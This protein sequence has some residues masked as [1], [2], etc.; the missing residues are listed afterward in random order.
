MRMRLLMFGLLA[1]FVL[2]GSAWAAPVTV[3]FS[4]L[5]STVDITVQ[6]NPAPLTLNGV[7]IQFD[8]Y[9]ISTDYASADSMGIYGHSENGPVVLNFNNGFPDTVGLPVRKLSLDFS[10]ESVTGPV[11]DDSGGFGLLAYVST[12]DGSVGDSVTLSGTYA[13]YDPNVPDL[14][15]VTGHLEYEGG[16][17]FDQATIWFAFPSLNYDIPLFTVS[18]IVYDT[19]PEPATMSLLA[20]GG[21]AMLRRKQK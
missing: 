20:L 6:N 4:V 14:G 2:A 13:P 8:N 3:D 16:I 1:Q 9:G 18:N 7:N 11:P 5:A 12:A 19:V 21:L 10:L 17:A 15:S